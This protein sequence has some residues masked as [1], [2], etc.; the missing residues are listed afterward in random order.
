VIEFHAEVAALN[1]SSRA[2][3]ALDEAYEKKTWHG[4]NLKQS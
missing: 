1:P 3:V 2:R 4:P